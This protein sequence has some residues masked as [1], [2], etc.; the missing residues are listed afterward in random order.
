MKQIFLFIFCLGLLFSCVKKRE[1]IFH[2]KAINPVTGAPYAGLEWGVS[3]TKTGAN[4]EK[5]VYEEGGTLDANGEAFLTLKVKGERTYNIGCKKP[6][7]TCYV[8][9][10]SFTYAVQDAPK[11]TFL[12]EFAPCAYMKF[13][14]ANQ[15]CE[16]PND[17][18]SYEDRFN[19]T[20]W[21]IGTYGIFGCFQNESNG[22]D[23][24]PAG[25]RIYRWRVE[26]STGTTEYIDSIY[27]NAGDSG[28]F[29][30]YY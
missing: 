8:K 25:L 5:K 22:Y 24:V 13:K 17:K 27:L 2:I 16:G 28:I 20:D 1:E 12:F 21:R 4:G 30:M 19:Y 10:I 29:E 14:I 11:P 7:N 9:Q 26:R 3:A 6:G 18:L 15:N 23:A